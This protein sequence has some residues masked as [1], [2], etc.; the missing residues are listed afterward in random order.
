MRTWNFSG[1]SHLT[2]YCKRQNFSRCQHPLQ[3]HAGIPTN[4]ELLQALDKLEDGDI[5]SNASSEESLASQNAAQD[6]A[7][8][9]VSQLPQSPLTD[10]KLNAARFGHKKPKLLPKKQELSPFQLRLNKNP[11]GIVA[12]ARV[13]VMSVP[14]H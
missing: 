7:S 8:R 5:S 1:R 13:F 2:P 14:F 11:Y 4:E 10:P 12:F 3:L 9:V 6:V